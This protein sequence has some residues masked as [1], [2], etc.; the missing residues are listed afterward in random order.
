MDDLVDAADN[1]G[2]AS[3]SLYPDHITC[4]Q[5]GQIVPVVITVT[6][7]NNNVTTC[8]SK[9][10]VAGLPCNWSEHPDGVGCA[11]GNNIAYNS[12]NG[13]FTATSTNCFYGPPY[14]SDATSF[15]QRTLCGDA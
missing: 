13:V 12:S 7:I 9:I 3:I 15:A 4:E 5:L 10:T 6:D 8:T 11:G 14:S 2:V 1:C